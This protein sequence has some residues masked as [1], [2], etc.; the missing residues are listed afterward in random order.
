MKSIDKHR[1]LDTERDTGR[2][3]SEQTELV[4]LIV[5]YSYMVGWLA[6]LCAALV[7]ALKIMWHTIPCRV[8]FKINH[9][10]TSRCLI[11]AL[12]CSDALHHI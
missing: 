8:L 3:M 5:L 7:P 11:C 4:A 6:G 9:N 12:L 10:S 2:E 1:R